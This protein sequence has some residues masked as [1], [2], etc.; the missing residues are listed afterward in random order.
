MDIIQICA[1]VLI[2][3]FTTVFSVGCF[4][5]TCG[6]IMVLLGKDKDN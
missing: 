5:L 3:S 1:T 6:M 4:C 2:V